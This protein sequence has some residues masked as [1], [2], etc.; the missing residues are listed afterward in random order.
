M[1]N[2]AE[3]EAAKYAPGES[4]FALAFWLSDEIQHEWQT[5][6]P[7]GH[8]REDGTLDI[9]MPAAAP[10][11][12]G[13]MRTQHCGVATKPMGFGVRACV[14]PDSTVY[15]AARRREVRRR[16]R[17]AGAASEVR[18]PLPPRRPQA[19][20]RTVLRYS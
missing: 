19:A 17:I 7:N 9:P 5:E 8:L 11:S 20:S 12:L 10:I 13:P 14:P 1:S 3:H 4:G 2:G 6:I 16:H 15:S 18:C